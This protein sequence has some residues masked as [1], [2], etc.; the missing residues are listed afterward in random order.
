MVPIQLPL[1]TIDI[2][3]SVVVS[4]ALLVFSLQMAN[5]CQ[6]GLNR[7]LEKVCGTAQRQQVLGALIATRVIC[8]L[9]ASWSTYSP[10]LK[11]LFLKINGY[12][13]FKTNITEV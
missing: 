4:E 2:S 12:D 10:N 5:L 3:L 1:V 8:E 13:C 6:L 11:F 7:H 9:A